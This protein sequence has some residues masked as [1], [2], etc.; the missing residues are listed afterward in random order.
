MHSTYNIHNIIG[1]YKQ[2]NFNVKFWL[3]KEDVHWNMAEVLEGNIYHSFPLECTHY[4]LQ[5]RDDSNDSLQTL[6]HHKRSVTFYQLCEILL[7]I[8]C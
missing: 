1:G 3:T 6:Q 8:A 5:S 7:S 2:L 4:V